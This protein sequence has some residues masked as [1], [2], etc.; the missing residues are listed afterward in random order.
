MDLS[1]TE[2]PAVLFD[3]AYAPYSATLFDGLRIDVSTDCGET[4]VPSSYF[5]EN[6]D[7][8]TVPVQTASWAPGSSADWRRDTAE[9]AAFT[10]MDANVSFINI[11]NYGNGLYIDNIMIEDLCA[12]YTL[13]TVQ[14]VNNLCF[15]ASLGSIDI[16][17]AAGTSPYTYNWSNGASSQDLTNIEAGSYDVT[18]TDKSG[19]VRNGTY[20]VTEGAEIIA[21][22]SKQNVNCNGAS[23]GSV[24]VSAGGGVAPFSY[25][26]NTVPAQTGSSISGLGPAFYT[27]TITDNIGCTKTSEVEVREP[28]VLMA[29]AVP[30]QPTSPNFNNG[31][32]NLLVTGGIAPYTYTWS[33]GVTTED[34][35]NL[36]QGTYF[37][38]V[39][40]RRGCAQLVTVVLT[41]SLFAP[42]QSDREVPKD[43]SVFLESIVYP[44]PTN[45]N[46]TVS[47][48]AIDK[49]NISIE[50]YDVN[51]SSLIDKSKSVS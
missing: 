19:C 35:Y 15:G 14:V 46:V 28:D 7:L 47:F 44:N 37:C 29:F 5:K 40:D 9:L 43:Q 41:N 13:N 42:F 38:T 32:I 45:G 50:V 31:E 33:N 21:T 34:N 12:G 49:G 1:G 20:I 10:G 17:I 25:S 48:T 18:V 24:S 39:V 51:G 8:A 22:T 27:V 26:W 3:V 23:D 30:A 4:Y 11:N 16:D 36:V 6:L 2:I